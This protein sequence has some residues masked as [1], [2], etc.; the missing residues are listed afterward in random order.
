[1]LHKDVGIGRPFDGI[2]DAVV[3]ADPRTGRIVPW[4]K[5]TTEIFAYLPS[6][7]LELDIDALLPKSPRAA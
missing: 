5:A 6:E 7:A 4:N 3:A 1:M 2:R